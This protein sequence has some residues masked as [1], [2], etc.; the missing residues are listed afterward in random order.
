MLR[1]DKEGNALYTKDFGGIRIF[2]S[3]AEPLF[4]SQLLDYM[5]NAHTVDIT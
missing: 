5:T 3:K 1:L 4:V 2:V